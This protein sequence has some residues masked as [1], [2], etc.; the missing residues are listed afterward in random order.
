MN[1]I[2]RTAPNRTATGPPLWGGFVEKPWRFSTHVGPPGERF[3]DEKLRVFFNTAR[4]RAAA[5]AL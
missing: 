2:Y 3:F 5:G 4:K 1:R